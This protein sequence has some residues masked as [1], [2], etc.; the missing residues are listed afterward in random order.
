MKGYQIIEL[1]KAKPL[2]EINDD[3]LQQDYNYVFATDLMSDALAMIQTNPEKTVLLTGLC[4]HQTLRTAEILDV[5]LII[6]VRGKILDAQEIDNYDDKSNVFST[7]L[8]MY[9][10]CGILYQNELKGPILDV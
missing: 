4:N 9:E 3:L 8:T 5:G 2:K 6:F 1:L 7:T 10:A